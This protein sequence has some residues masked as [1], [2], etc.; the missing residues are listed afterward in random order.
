MEIGWNSVLA[1]LVNFHVGRTNKRLLSRMDALVYY[2]SRRPWEF[3]E[4]KDFKDL[5]TDRFEGIVRMDKK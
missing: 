1:Y 3:C 5:A 2:E 4:S